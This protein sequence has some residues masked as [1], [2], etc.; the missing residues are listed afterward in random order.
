MIEDILN[1]N[2]WGAQSIDSQIEFAD[3]SRERNKKPQIWFNVSQ[4]LSPLTLYKYLKAR[5]GSPNGFVMFLK[6][7]SS[8]N[9][10]H[11]HYAL[12]AP[13]AVIN[14]W[15]KTSGLEIS[16][17][18]FLGESLEE[19]HWEALILNLYA[20][21]RKYGDEMKKVQSTF[22]QWALFINPFNRVENAVQDC[23]NQLLRLN[24]KSVEVPSG[25]QE[26][27]DK[28][29]KDLNR[30]TKNISK[31]ATLGTTIRMLC[32]VV[33][34]SFINLILLVFRKNEYKTDERLYESL[35]RE[36]IDIRVKTLHLHCTCFP[37][38]IDC[39]TSAFKNFH[40]LMNRRNDFLHGNVDPI[41]LV[42]EDVWFDHNTIPLFQEDEGVIQKMMRN[43]CTNV[44]PE[45][46][47]HDFQSVSKFIELVLMSMDD[48]SFQLFVQLMC[49]RM[50]GINKKT[51]RLGVLFPS[52]YL[53]ENHLVTES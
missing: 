1:P 34:E 16:I 22:E 26:S 20:D 6:N 40:S 15:G 8:D 12:Q 31:A 48:T 3:K 52:E 45:K 50:P 2:N 39:S 33:C 44:E 38:Q 7:Q 49:D 32:P 27:L 28:Y 11:W 42:V 5:F 25:S 23:I 14:I 13:N 37:K 4:K 18:S 17:N 19:K 30:W 43:Y 21:F 35:I 29:N 51:R 10:I 24:L 46:A 47:L 9:L 36:Q 53:V 41:K